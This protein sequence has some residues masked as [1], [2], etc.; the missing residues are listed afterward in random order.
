MHGYIIKIV[1]KALLAVLP[2]SVA[3][4]QQ[5]FVKLLSIG[6]PYH[7]EIFT[8]VLLKLQ[9]DLSTPVVLLLL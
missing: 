1:L 3:V 4:E 7:L 5:Q 9:E 2:W 8:E 6:S